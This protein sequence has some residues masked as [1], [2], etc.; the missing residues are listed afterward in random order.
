MTSIQTEFSRIM[1]EFLAAPVVSIKD[2]FA[3]H[4]T[5]KQFAQ[6]AAR[7]KYG[8]RLDTVENLLSMAGY[9]LV[10]VKEDDD[11]ATEQA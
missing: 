11:K 3:K 4:C 5:A 1:E 10:I 6:S 2:K 8:A 9:K 7:A